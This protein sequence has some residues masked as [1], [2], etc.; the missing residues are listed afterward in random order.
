MVGDALSRK[1]EDEGFLFFLSLIVPDC[2]QV[3]CKEWLQDPK[4]SHM[5]QQLQANSPI[6]IGHS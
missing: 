2:L 5:I 4:L 6:S 3:V 1:Y